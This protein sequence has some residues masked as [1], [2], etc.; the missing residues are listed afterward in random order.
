MIVREVTIGDCR[1]I[2]GDCL[3]VLPGLERGS[4]DAEVTDATIYRHEKP[5]E[6]KSKTFR[7]ISPFVGKQKGRNHYALRGRMVA[8]K[9]CRQVW[10]FTMCSVEGHAKNGHSGKAQIQNRKT[11]RSLY[12]R[13]RDNALQVNGK[14]EDLRPLR[15]NY[16]SLHSPQGRKPLQQLPRK[17]GGVVHVMSQQ[18]AQETVVGQ[19]QIIGRVKDL[20][21]FDIAC[22]R[23]REAYDAQ[24]LFGGIK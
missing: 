2:Q 21:Y 16:E 3:A 11:K 1:L 5:T 8:T 17:L 24:A 7:T 4:M 10:C 22:R 23:I 20:G 12:S 15:S 18:H 6:R 14:E 9:T 13:K 19:A